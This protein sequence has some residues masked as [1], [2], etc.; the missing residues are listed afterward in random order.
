MKI[1]A[2][3]PRERETIRHM[4][5]TNLLYSKDVLEAFIHGTNHTEYETTITQ[6]WSK[7]P[8]VPEY[9]VA[10]KIIKHHVQQIKDV[11]AFKDAFWEPDEP[12]ATE[13]SSSAKSFDQ[14]I[15]V[16]ED[17]ADDAVHS[18]RLTNL[19]EGQK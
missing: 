12:V 15:T 18:E 14:L 2:F 1:K 5:V 17:V 13:T 9:I 10:D 19:K 6:T 4:M 3:S 16:A 7:D 8:S 11:R